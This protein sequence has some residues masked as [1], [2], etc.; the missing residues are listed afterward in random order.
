MSDVSLDYFL[1]TLDEELRD[2]IHQ[3]DQATILKAAEV[4]ARSI[5][6]G[7]RLH[8]T[9]IGKPS[10]VSRYMSALFSSTGTPAYFLDATEAIHGSAGQVLEKDVVIII[11]NSGE[12]PELQ[13]TVRALKNMGITLIAVTGNASSWLASE[14]AVTLWAGIAKEGD[15]LN[16]PPR[17]SI[18]VELIILQA[19]SIVLQE[20]HQLDLEQYH[21]WHPGGAL[22][23]SLER[24]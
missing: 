17:A 16:K 10:H 7:G 15:R 18:L 21:A 12:T 14:V 1:N 22:G 11:S 6:N 8:L 20:K 23:K 4:I 13:D 2:F 9:G 24:R 5:Q 3:I 19:L